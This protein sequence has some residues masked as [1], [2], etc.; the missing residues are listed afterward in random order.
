MDILEVYPKDWHV[1]FELSL[2]EVQK[3]LDFLDNCEFQGDPKSREM[4]EA[5]DYVIGDFFPKLDK[6]TED[7]LR[8]EI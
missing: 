8:R 4:I 6:L 5:K 1:R 7:M 3:I 2:T